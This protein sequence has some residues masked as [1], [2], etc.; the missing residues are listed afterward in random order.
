MSPGEETR[1]VFAG[2]RGKAQQHYAV[3]NWRDS[4]DITS[5]YFTRFGDDITEKDLW[6]HFKKWGDVREIF[7]P[8]RR[9]YNGR[10]Y[11]FVR[12]KGIRDT[13]HTARQ[14]D[15]IVIGGLKLYVN[16]PKYGREKPRKEDTGSKSLNQK[17]KPQ[18]EGNRARQEDHTAPVSYL[19]ALTHTN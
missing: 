6:Y 5:F 11:G 1:Q 12:F 18:I 10:R 15:K 3:T 19:D 14:L 17:V 9:N 8:N 4:R 2:N 13:Q 7:I 16:V